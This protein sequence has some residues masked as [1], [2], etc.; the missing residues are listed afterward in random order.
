MFAVPSSPDQGPASSPDDGEFV[1]L[2]T[3]NQK[4]ILAFLVALVPRVADAED[5]LQRTNL[6]LWRKRQQFELGTNFKAWA[7]AIARWEA[8]AFL[9]ESRRQGWLVFNDELA[10]LVA[11]RMASL[12]DSQID[13][14]PDSLRHCLGQLSESHRQLVFERYSR[15]L[16]LRECSERFD[17]SEQGLKVTLHR[18]RITLRRCVSKFS[19]RP[20]QP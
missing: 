2:M 12:P 1:A 8:L 9:R 3:R 4:S 13:S 15:G 11:E 18:L 20:L 7:F 14:M 5:I 10:S 17:R 16:S 6:V 19:K